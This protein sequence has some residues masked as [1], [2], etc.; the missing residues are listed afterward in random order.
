[1]VLVFLFSHGV[2]CSCIYKYHV[3]VATQEI[4]NTFVL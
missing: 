4:F 3:C 1:M 2:S